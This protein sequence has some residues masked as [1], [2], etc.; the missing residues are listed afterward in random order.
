VAK[1]QEKIVEGGEEER[2]EKELENMM[3]GKEGEEEEEMVV[4]PSRTI[5][6]HAR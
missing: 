4:E 2:E 1:E 5:P 3:E 6:I